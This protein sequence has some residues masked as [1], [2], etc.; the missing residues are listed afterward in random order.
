MRMDESEAESTIV[1]RAVVNEEEQYS[2]WPADQ[3]LPPGW[4]DG[5]RTGSKSECLDHI[6]R[7]WTDMRP[8]SLRRHLEEI[9]RHPPVET[10]T[11]EPEPI[12]DLVSRLCTGEHPL[13]FATRAQRTAETFKTAIDHDYA[14]VRFTGTQGGTELDLS[15]DRAATRMD[16]A[17]F[18]EGN[19]TV[20]L[21]GTLVLDF[22]PVRCVANIDLT[23]LSGTGHLERL[24]ISPP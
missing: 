13:E 20:H 7:V 6:E 12:D 16:G 24:S 1:Y 21:V 11:P 18:V 15:L 17:D 23:T 10:V 5:G 3:P 22:V 2:I 8:L 4:A 9:A 14:R 19:G